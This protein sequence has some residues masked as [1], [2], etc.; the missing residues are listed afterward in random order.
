M[1]GRQDSNLRPHAPQTCALPGCATTRFD[2]CKS[3]AKEFFLRKYSNKY[4][5]HENKNLRFLLV[6]C[7]ALSCCNLFK[8]HICF[9]VYF[10]KLI[11]N[12]LSKMIAKPPICKASMVS[13]PQKAPNN[14]AT[15]GFT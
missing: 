14:T 15:T 11:I 13:P 1:S 7:K 8:N 5:Y 9:F 3:N 4:Y 10:S 6:Y 12:T 2:R